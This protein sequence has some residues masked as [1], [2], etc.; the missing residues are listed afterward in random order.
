MKLS[1]YF[2]KKNKYSYF[3]NRGDDDISDP[4]NRVWS[5]S[6]KGRRCVDDT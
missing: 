3:D 5:S 4:D 6:I 1:S 2:P